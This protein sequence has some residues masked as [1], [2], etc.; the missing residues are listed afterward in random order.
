M[1]FVIIILL[2]LFFIDLVISLD[3][4]FLLSFFG[5]GRGVVC[6]FAYLFVYY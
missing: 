4:S 3:F 5:G 1:C 6:L 2:F